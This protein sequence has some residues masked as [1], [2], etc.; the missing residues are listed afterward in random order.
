[1]AGITLA[2]AEAKL[3]EVQEA[4][5]AALTSQEYSVGGKRQRRADLDALQRAI[6][7]WEK[8]VHQ[9]TN[10]GIRVRGVTPC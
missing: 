2:Q 3:T 9:L 1:M 7:Y 10:G 5:S 8:K 4:Y 6:D